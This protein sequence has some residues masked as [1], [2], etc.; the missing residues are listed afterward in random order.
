[1]RKIQAASLTERWKLIILVVAAAALSLKLYLALTTDGS[2]DVPGFEDWREKVQQFGVLGTYHRIGKFN[3]P[4]NHTPFVPQLLRT[5]GF[6]TESTPLPFKFWLRLPAI[7]ADTGSLLLVWKILEQSRLKFRPSTLVL[8]AACP[9]SI[10]VSGFHG[11]VDPVMIFFLLLSL[12]LIESGRASWLAGIAFG[13]SMS[14]KV[15]PIIFAPAI[16]FY[17]S[18]L[19]ERIVFFLSAGL[20]FTA[21]SLPYML[22]EPITILKAIFGFGSIYGAWGWTRILVWSTGAEPYIKGN[23]FQLTEWH[24]AISRF[25]RYFMMWAICAASFLMN[26]RATKTPLFVQSGVVAFLFMFLTPGYGIQYQAWLVPWGLALG[27]RQLIIYYAV[28]SAYVS[29]EYLCWANWN[30]FPSICIPQNLWTLGVACWCSVL[31]ILMCYAHA[32][33]KPGS[34]FCPLPG[35]AELE[36]H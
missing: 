16:F 32:L 17:L 13:M 12:Y 24:S 36:E 21:I 1:M 22:Q 20:F 29:I 35:V 15:V 9:I 27:V 28:G 5:M 11:Q 31:V 33:M 7:L 3:N 19:R 8:M 26:R 10:L 25:G 4:F 30:A 6:L 18:T 23:I 34:V 14:I 2:L